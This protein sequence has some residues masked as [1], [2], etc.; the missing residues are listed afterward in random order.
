MPAEAVGAPTKS[1]MF[2]AGAAGVGVGGAVTK[3]IGMPFGEIGI[4]VVV[5]F[6][7]VVDTVVGTVLLTTSGFAG[8][9]PHA[10]A[11]SATTGSTIARQPTLTLRRSDIIVLLHQSMLLKRPNR[12]PP[13][14][15]L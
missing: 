1:E 14:A 3:W 15:S 9:P 4:D 7:V 5:V 10:M 12:V 8:V 11:P 2:Q 6:T 13:P